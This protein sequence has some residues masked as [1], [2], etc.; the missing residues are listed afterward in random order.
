MKKLVA[1]AFVGAA[2]V[3]TGAM[4]NDQYQDEHAQGSVKLKENENKIWALTTTTTTAPMAKAE[5][6]AEKMECPEPQASSEMAPGADA[7][8]AQ[9]AA[10]EPVVAIRDRVGFETGSSELTDSSKESLGQVATLLEQNPQISPV[11]ISGHTD[12]TG[13][14]KVNDQ[15]SEKRAESV[16]SFLEEKGIDSSRFEISSSGSSDPVA[17]NDT[18]SGR[19]MNRRVEINYAD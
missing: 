9:Q 11:Q 15:L 6:P 5:K 7:L 19:A 4:A 1:S 12:S 14:S 17:S 10:A 3:T 13:S 18:A 8:A 16:R 2:L